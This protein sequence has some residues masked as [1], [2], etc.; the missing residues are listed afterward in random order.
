M[1]ST[2]YL[3][4]ALRC[5]DGKR[6]YIRAKTQ[7]E[8][9]EK[10]QRAQ[11]ELCMGI[12]IG[13]NTTFRELAQTWMDFCKRPKVSENTI[14]LIRVLMDYHVLPYI[15]HLQV[16][17]I[18]PVHIAHVMSEA[19]ALAKGTQAALLSRMREVFQ[20]AIDNRVIAVNPVT[21]QFKP[22]GA[23]PAER[24]PLT[25]GQVRALLAAA[26]SKGDDLYTFV[27]LGLFAGLRRGEALGLCWD[28]VD[29]VNRTIT[30]QRQAVFHKSGA[31]LTDRLKTQS[32]KRVLPI[33]D[34]LLEALRQRRR[35]SDT[36]TVV[37]A[38]DM[39]FAKRLA[40]RLELL[41]AVDHNGTVIRRN[42]P[43]DFYVHPH[44]LRHTYASRLMATG[45]DLKE[46]QYLLGHTTPA[47]TLRVYTHYD[48]KSRQ[49]ETAEKVDA[50]FR[51]ESS[52]I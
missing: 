26:K 33:P 14:H 6:K 9:D 8:L 38:L 1:A 17:D 3:T 24:V 21:S 13:D 18:R 20:F 35:T 51:P 45:A 31:V 12:N 34:V 10:V 36:M 5:P 39:Q 50:A 30:V 46:V 19:A 23:P 32:A 11:L 47:M 29:F 16:R 49:R 25:E 7:K 27:C 22:G 44:L 43:L 15:G 40:R 42:A 4:K 37:G 52:A 48:M 41:C 2:K 28:S